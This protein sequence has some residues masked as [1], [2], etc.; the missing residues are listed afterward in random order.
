MRLGVIGTGYVGLVAGAGFS[1]F[2]NDVVCADVDGD[3]IARLLAGEI[4]IYE[5]GLEPLVRRNVAQGRLR[6][7]AN[8]AEAIAGADVAIIAVGTPQ[9]GDGAA[10][11]SYVIAAAEA[12]GRAM[13][14]PLV[15]VTKST[16]PVGTADL[17]REAVGQHARH[18]FAVASNPEFLKEGDAVN[19]F[20][21]PDRVLIGTDD[22]RAREVLRLLYA[23]FVRT[24]DRVQ[25]MDARSAELAKYAAN[26]MLATRVSLMNEIANLAE[27][28]GADVEHVRRGIGA[29]P[30]IGPKFL[31]PG[32]GYGGSCFPKDIKALLHT[33]GRAD[34]PLDILGAVDRVNARQKAIL[35]TK[36]ERQLGDLAGRKVAVWGLAFKPNTD[37][38]REAPALSLIDRLLA[39]G[40]KVTAFDPAAMPNVERV[41]GDKVA[42]APGMYDAL[43]GADALALVT[44]W[45]EFRRPDFGRIKKL[46]RS[47]LVFD[48]RNIWDPEEL[49]RLGFTY[50]GIGRR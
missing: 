34:V 10:D 44:E 48:G 26:A 47:P 1:D 23:P 16:V 3:K 33:A 18:P 8:L 11:L 36:I 19:D 35:A 7:T 21:K 45:H 17:V 12:I 38:I 6:F 13:T 30:R 15:I 40:A 41:Y 29:D 25:L 4:P 37:D 39:M 46:L 31:F 28:L 42:M 32:T 5:P 20:M 22:E 14:G 2:G 50:H 49:R 43:D 9:G 27:K 24:N